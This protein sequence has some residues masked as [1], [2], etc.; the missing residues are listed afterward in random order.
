MKKGIIAIAF[1]G[2]I[3]QNDA[4]SANYVYPDSNAEWANV[5]AS[6]P[7]NS[8]LYMEIKGDSPIYTI[9][10]TNKGIVY[11]YR[12]KLPGRGGS[13]CAMVMLLAGGPTTD[14]KKLTEKL[15]DLL[16]YAVRQRSASDISQDVLN[17]KLSGCASFFD[18]QYQSQDFVNSF[19]AD[20]AKEALCVY[21]TEGELFMMLENPYQ[22][23]YMDY[24]CIHFVPAEANACPST[25]V[26]CIKSGLQKTFFFQLPKDVEV[27]G[28]KKCI[29]EN[30]FFQLVYHRQGYNDFTTVSL[31]S[32]Q[33]DYF[34]VSGNIINVKSA[35]ECRV[36]FE[37]KIKIE[38]FDKSNNRIEKYQCSIG[39]NVFFCELDKNDELDLEDGVHTIQVTA[40]GYKAISANIDTSKIKKI[41]I[42]LEPIG[43]RKKVYLKPAHS[44]RY[45]NYNEEPCE[46]SFAANNS[47]YKKYESDLNP[48]KKDIPTFYVMSKRQTPIIPFVV[49]IAVLALLCC[50]VGYKAYNYKGELDK[51][52]IAIAAS[53]S[54]QQAAPEESPEMNSEPVSEEEPNTEARNVKDDVNYLNENN[55]WEYS[56][57]KSEKYKLFFVKVVLNGDDFKNIVTY[58][59]IYDEITNANWRKLKEIMKSYDPKNKTEFKKY[60]Y[61]N[62]IY[63]QDG[64]GLSKQAGDLL[65]TSKD[66]DPDKWPSGTTGKF[67]LNIEAAVTEK[68]T[69]S[70]SDNERIKDNIDG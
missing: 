63:S 48:Q 14:G 46:V 27:K 51:M 68:A 53:D 15:Q 33:S 70:H 31:Q 60:N 52:K 19:P 16:D 30:D 44:K 28:G 67:I 56:K 24:T 39:T 58:Y 25:N 69:T 64:T 32:G 49:V 12:K 47:F 66:P 54:L 26:E 11:A 40:D 23:S 59:D 4:S 2:Q 13:D 36:P 65:K 55:I 35:S 17:E 43:L 45:T 61:G 37:K 38:V 18:T 41:K 22:P 6:D 3:Y 9:K 50:G 7:R 10:I 57:L 62:L 21:A 20:P 8:M 5:L 29:A 1:K 42:T 34:T